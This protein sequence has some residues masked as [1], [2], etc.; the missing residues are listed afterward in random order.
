VQVSITSREISYDSRFRL[1]KFLDIAKTVMA[2][3]NVTP[4]ET[5][6]KMVGDLHA[7]VTQEAAAARR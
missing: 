3:R 1:D 7:R 2:R 4:S 6:L 5:Y